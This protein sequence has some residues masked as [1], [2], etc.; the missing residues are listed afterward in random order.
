MVVRETPSAS[1]IVF[2]V[3][4][5]L[6]L[7]LYSPIASTHLIDPELDRYSNATS[8][9]CQPHLPIPAGTQKRSGGAPYPAL[10]AAIAT[11]EATERFVTPS[12]I[13]GRGQGEGSVV[14]ITM[15]PWSQT[16][17]AYEPPLRRGLAFTQPSPVNRRGLSFLPCVHL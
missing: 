4:A 10:R 5:S 8:A 14:L 7:S 13:Y 11:N 1:A 2:S 3:T 6:F 17:S 16:A 15:V 9:Q 12:P